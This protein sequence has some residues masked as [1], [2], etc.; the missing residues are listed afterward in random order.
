MIIWLRGM[1]K[2]FCYFTQFH[3]SLFTLWTKFHDKGITCK[4]YIPQKFVYNYVVVAA[5]HVL[6]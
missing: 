4:I 3:E 2:Y 6:L 5:R 1:W